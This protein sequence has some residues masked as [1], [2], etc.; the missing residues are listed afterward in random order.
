MGKEKG[1]LLIIAGIAFF[2]AGIFTYVSWLVG[3]LMIIWG[4]LEL[5]REEEPEREV[6]NE[7][8]MRKKDKRLEFLR[9]SFLVQIVVFL[10]TLP[11]FS[12]VEPLLLMF[13]IVFDSVTAILLLK[14]LVDDP[15]WP[16]VVSLF[17][18]THIFFVFV[19][20]FYYFPDAY[21]IMIMLL[22]SIT[23]IIATFYHGEFITFLSTNLRRIIPSRNNLTV[24][25]PVDNKSLHLNH[26]INTNTSDKVIYCIFCG[27]KNL[28]SSSYCKQCG[29]QMVK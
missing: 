17:P 28:L 26:S 24:S 29:K 10:A 2:I 7:E 23:T 5:K 15:V 13:I 25:Q 12:E 9:I 18:I 11:L 14:A 6:T 19:L 16:R 27:T 4:I 3:I 8:L 22:I 1:I 21:I 20:I